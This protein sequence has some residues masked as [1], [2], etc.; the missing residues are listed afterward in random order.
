MA[1]AGHDVDAYWE[2]DGLIAELDS[3]EFHKT[4]RAFERDRGKAAALE[5][6]GYRVLMFTWRQ[7]RDEQALVAAAIRG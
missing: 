3:F 7:L 5:A 1:V 2:S 6:A 4:R